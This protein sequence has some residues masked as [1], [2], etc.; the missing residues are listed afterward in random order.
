[1]TAGFQ[2]IHAKPNRMWSAGLS[3]FLFVAVVAATCMWRTRAIVRI[4]KIA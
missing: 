3:W 2:L 1:M 4:P